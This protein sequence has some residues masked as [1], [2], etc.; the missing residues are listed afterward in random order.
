M[1]Y[2]GPWISEI[3]ELLHILAFKDFWQYFSENP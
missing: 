3:E 1:S 2:F